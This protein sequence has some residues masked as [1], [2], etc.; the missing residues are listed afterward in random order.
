MQLLAHGPEKLEMAMAIEGTG[1]MASTGFC[2][3]WLLGVSL[4]LLSQSEAGRC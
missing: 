2:C 1:A 3:S 4:A